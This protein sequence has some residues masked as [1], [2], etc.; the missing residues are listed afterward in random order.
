MFSANGAFAHFPYLLPNLICAGLMVISMSAGCFFLVETHPQ[1]RP[2]DASMVPDHEQPYRTR[3]YST[4]WQTQPT[5]NSPAANLTQESYGTFNAVDEE[6]VE[7]AWYL[8]P[9]GTSKPGSL[10]SW[11][12]QKA[13][14]KRV[15]MLTIALGLFTYHSMTYD[16]LLPVFLQSDRVTSGEQLASA[17]VPPVANNHGSLAGGLGLSVKNSGYIMAVNGV[18]ALFVQAV[19]FPIMA[20]RLGVWKLF[21]AVTVLHP[22]AYFIVPWLALLPTSVLYPGVYVC[23]MIR[24][25][26]S[27]L[28]YP[29]LLILIKEAAPAPGCL[30]KINGL[31]ASTGAACRTIASPIA[32][33]LYGLGLSINFTA[34]AW[35][36][37]GLIAFAGALQVLTIK[38]DRSG[39]QYHVR[40]A[41]PFQQH[42][43]DSDG[44]RWLRHKPSVV[45]IQIRE[46]DSGYISEDESRPLIRRES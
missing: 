45:R 32:G 15:V 30:G 16:Y 9:D 39:P 33:L 44:Q 35:W 11:P 23:L 40:S 5:D 17:V 6:V 21:T 18:I 46:D 4:T 24:N 13:F 2:C 43:H 3:A 8:R 7:E 36:A 41:E 27:I 22:V 14:T 38:R 10:R 20:D 25:C 34:L 42:Q 19:V 29:L 31:A 12:P 37:S 28:A 26:L 1:F